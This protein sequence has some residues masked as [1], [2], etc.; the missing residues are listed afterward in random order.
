MLGSADTARSYSLRQRRAERRRPRMRSGRAREQK[1]S[2]VRHDGRRGTAATDPEGNSYGDGCIQIR[3]EDDGTVSPCSFR[4]QDAIW[5]G[6][7]G[8]GSGSFA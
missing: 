6:D 4:S 3:W 1:G 8:A 7:D 5:L 2:A